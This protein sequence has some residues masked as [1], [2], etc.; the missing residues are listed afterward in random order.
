MKGYFQTNE[1]TLLRS[2]GIVTLGANMLTQTRLQSCLPVWLQ[3]LLS[4][5]PLWVI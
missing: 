4:T 1:E 2:K 5:K 3:L